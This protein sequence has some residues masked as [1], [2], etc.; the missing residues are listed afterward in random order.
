MS[1][2][3]MIGPRPRHIK[4]AGKWFFS[5]AGPCTIAW[6]VISGCFLVSAGVI[7]LFDFVLAG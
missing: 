2:Q 4:K 7:W 5:M 6:L 1:G 3:I